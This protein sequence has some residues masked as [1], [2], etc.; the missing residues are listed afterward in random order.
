M[1]SG[2]GVGSSSLALGFGAGSHFDVVSVWLQIHGLLW[3]RAW[4][5]FH[6]GSA[7]GSRARATADVSARVTAKFDT[8]LTLMTMH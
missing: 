3:I 7:F 1:G 5:W 8:E 2:S 6:I 4:C